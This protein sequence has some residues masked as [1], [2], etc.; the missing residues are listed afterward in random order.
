[1]PLDV[2]ALV[3]ALK[4][5][6]TTLLFGAGSSLPS[7]APSVAQLQARFERAFGTSASGYNLAEQTSI[8][9]RRGPGRAAL[10]GE[11][12]KAILNVVP[13]GA[14][15]NLPLYN[16][17]SLYT[18]NYDEVIEVS[19]RR[20][21]RRLA[22]YSSN[23]DFGQ[24]VEPSDA[25]L[26]KLHGTIDKD[27][28]DGHHSRIILTESD[29]DHTSEFREKLYDRLRSDLADGLLVI[30]GH[31]LADPDIRSIIDRAAR[32]NR[33]SEGTGRVVLF[34]FERDDGRAGLV[35]DRGLE[36][37][38]GGLDDFFAAL[39]ARLGS[40]VIGPALTG[41][42]L[43]LVPAVRPSTVDVA[44]E[45][46]M[47]SA[48]IS[49]MYNGWP[50]SYA[51]IAA[52]LTFERDGAAAVVRTLR[53]QKKRAVVILGPSGVG[54]T[55]MA[56]Q[57]L[58]SLRAAGV[59]CWEHK[60]DQQLLGYRWREVA[61]LLKAAGTY[62]CLLIDEAHL[63]LPEINDMMDGL[64]SDD[65][66]HLSLVLVS[67][68][69]QWLPRIK[70]P[71][72][73]R[74]SI[75]VPLSRISQSEIEKLLNL[76]ESVS[77][78]RE[79]VEPAF[80]GFSRPERRRRLAQRCE[81]DMFVCLKNIFASEKLDD[82][83][84][85]EFAELESV[86]QDIYRVV[87]AMESS[88]VR[89]HRQL[90]IR[91]L[92]VPM[93]Q[94]AAILAQ[95]TGIVHETTIDERQG[96]YAWRGRHR[97]IMDI[98]AEYKYYN[99]HDKYK[100]FND[101]IDSVQPTYDIELKTI[102]EMCGDAGG[103]QSIPD[104]KK[105]NVL[106]RKML[107]VAPRERVPRHRLIRNL[108]SLGSYEIA[109]T[110]VRLFEKDFRLDGPAARYKIDLALARAIHTTGI[111]DEDRVVLL[112]KAAEVAA[113]ASARFSSNKQVLSAFAEVGLQLY[114]Y[115]GDQAVFDQALTELR[116]AEQKTGD[117]DVT[118]RIARFEDRITSLQSA[119]AE[120]EPLELDED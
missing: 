120:A 45:I 67:S 62:G 63:E 94:T 35:E 8:I 12:R 56:R 2:A 10:I 117:A 110:E 21:S 91:L 13:T 32:L 58:I 54:K 27:V 85:R 48:N 46:A 93:A 84:L 5:E 31:S 76:I 115:T 86:P 89:V 113:S 61:R 78:I 80:A 28:V 40:G 81:A 50:A 100:L 25:R 68:A 3:S 57:A 73:H 82:I 64:A 6:M 18:T 104:K 4:P 36:V 88:G 43:D 38:F 71:S 75:E 101:V 107:S 39:A 33:E 53:E 77:T 17:R 60:S 34:I 95:L 90:V 51:D 24:K 105:Q 14:V 112:E 7:L 20:K 55:T 83:I 9:E 22:S 59:T 116:L 52:G 102:R 41:D 26:Y 42:P 114:R 103:I 92:G 49:G 65:D 69:N 79:L 119:H 37:C 72:I 108:I 66:A 109:E 1:M 99:D 97:V 16:W 106:L 74:S 111:L 47:G 30:V 98:V 23:F 96:V 11:L 19:Y 15:L 118:R 44:H 29:Y 87:A 70:S